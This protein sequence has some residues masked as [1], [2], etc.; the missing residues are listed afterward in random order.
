MI[1]RSAPRVLVLVLMFL[2]ACA[3]FLTIAPPAAHA[4]DTTAITVIV[5]DESSKRVPDVAIAVT[6]DGF[7][8]QT[9][10]TDEKG[11]ATISLPAGSTYTFTA[12]VDSLPAGA[13]GFVDNPK[14]VDVQGIPT[15]VR[16]DVGEPQAAQASES[17]GASE[18]ASEPATVTPGD[19][20]S[21]GATDMGTQ[22]TQKVLSGLVFGLIL[23]LASIGVSLIYG[24]TGLNNFAHGEMVTFGGFVAFTATSS[25]AVGSWAGLVIALILGAVLGWLQ[26]LGIWKPLRRKGVGLIP[27]MIVSIGLSL[28][29]RY[30]FAFVWSPGRYTMDQ[31]FSPLISIFGVGLTYWNVMGSVV[32]IVLIV[33]VAYVLNYTQI[34]KATRAVA[35]NKPLAAASGINVDR[36]IR[37]VWIG[38][39]ALAAIAGVLIA[40]YQTISFQSG[41]SI[42]LLIFAA[43]TLGGLGTTYGALI[44][45]LLLS[46][47][48]ELSTFFIPTSLKYVV[49]MLIMILILLVRPQGL[50]GKKQRVG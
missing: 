7:T 13:P 40:Y 39:G 15:T 27:I 50:L 10:T 6:A 44:G 30:V 37:V 19:D 36:V 26:D 29:L 8:E 16:F 5:I 22:I 2:A 45:S 21:T 11:A 3:A 9:I 32:S 47:I 43:T 49:A 4:A 38:S 18:T 46:L 12:D 23:A 1:T 20:G 48:I 17:A 14:I 31:D 33:A 42:L 34:G 41:A 24:T 25:F 28:L 35:D